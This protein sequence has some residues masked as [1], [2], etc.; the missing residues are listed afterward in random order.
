MLKGIACIERG[1]CRGHSTG[2]RE[3]DDEI[4]SGEQARLV[5]GERMEGKAGWKKPALG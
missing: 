5:V 1:L 3:R 4:G 2:E